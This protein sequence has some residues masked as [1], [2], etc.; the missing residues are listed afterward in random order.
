MILQRVGGKIQPF[1]QEG[2][3]ESRKLASKPPAEE[4]TNL[5]GDRI[6]I[7]MREL[8][9]LSASRRTDLVACYP[10]IFLERL[11]DY[12]PQDV[13]SV[14]IWT[15]NPRN[16]I[17]EG[18]LRRVLKNYRQIFV[19]LTITGMGAGEFE[20]MTSPWEETVAMIRPLVDLTGDPRRIAW[21][22]D[23]ILEAESSKETYGNFALFP[24]L[25]S[26]IASFGIETCRVSWVSPYRKVVARLA[27]KGWRLKS[28]DPETRKKQAEE[29]E[30]IASRNGMR[31]FFCS[32]E[33]FPVSKC[34]D[35]AFLSD[36]HPDRLS[37]SRERAKGQRPLCGCTESLDIGWYSLRCRQ[38]CLYCYAS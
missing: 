36:I 23:P 32:M 28:R 31:V 13:H 2:A 7:S 26:A 8:L 18:E 30:T 34:I 37:A 1:Y 33:G 3:R 17:A 21:R 6:I 25:A 5:S 16:M 9:I 20:P 4:L 22:F 27:K 19:H 35:G 11:R 14:V 29:L 12:P 38:G 10:D 24:T 15:K